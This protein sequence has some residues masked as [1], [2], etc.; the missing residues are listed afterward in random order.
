M[1]HGK[2]SRLVAALV[3]AALSACGTAGAAKEEDGPP[4][5]VERVKGTRQRRVTLTPRAARRIGLKVVPISGATGGETVVPYAAL[6]YDPSGRTWV[7][8]QVKPRAYQRARVTV[9]RIEGDQVFLSASPPVGTRAVS[10][11]AAEVY[12]T[13]FFSGHE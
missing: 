5:R 8:K 3:V 7:Y 12:G 4:A 11:G 13:E 6:L 2:G 9:D 10:V 1:A